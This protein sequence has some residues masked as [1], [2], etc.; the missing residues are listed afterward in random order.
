MIDIHC[1]ILPGLDDGP[2]TFEDSLQMCRIAVSEGIEQIVAAPHIK[3]NSY[4]LPKSQRLLKSDIITQTDALNS[5]LRTEGLQLNLIPAAAVHFEWD[6]FERIIAGEVPLLG[7]SPPRPRGGPNDSTLG[8]PA[9]GEV[10]YLLLELPLDVIPPH[11]G[12]FIH[13]LLLKGIVPII[14]HPERIYEVQENL[15][16]LYRLVRLGAL[17]Q[18]AA[19]SLTGEF[20]VKAERTVK[21]M[22]KSRLA[23]MIGTEAHST[24]ERPPLLS[25]ALKVASK[26]I[27]SEEAMAMVTETPGRILRGE[28][29]EPAEPL[30]PK[31]RWSFPWLGFSGK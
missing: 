27:G 1:H 6:L 14:T 21:S 2:N 4:R 12:Q 23:A 31:R 20:G 25:P 19:M 7:A 5:L 10:R 22:L 30:A 29:M 8:P 26:L 13:E 28:Y 16:S 9:G 24:R 18:V 15:Q 3:R 17:V 11:L